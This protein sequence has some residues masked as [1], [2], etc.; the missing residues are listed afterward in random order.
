M[1][2][3]FLAALVDSVRLLK[4]PRFRIRFGKRLLKQIAGLGETSFGADAG[5]DFCRARCVRFVA[6][7][8][9]NLTGRYFGVV[10]LARNAA[11]SSKPCEPGCVIRLVVAIRNDQHGTT[12]SHGFAGCADPSLMHNYTGPQKN[13]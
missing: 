5:A 13:R 8:R 11:S 10:T 4:H 2:G 9:G 1:A 12:G 7:K 6:K 3:G